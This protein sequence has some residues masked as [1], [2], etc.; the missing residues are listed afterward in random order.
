[1]H[2]T[3]FS[4]TIYAVR[5]K[6]S[7]S[8]SFN[9]YSNC[10]YERLDRNPSCLSSSSS[11][12]RC[13]GC[14][15]IS[16]Y[17]VPITPSLLCGL[18]QSSLLQWSSSRRLILSG[19]DRY[20]YRL[21]VYSPKMSCCELNCSVKE[22]SVCDRRRRIKEICFCTFSDEAS[23]ISHSDGYDEA[24]AVLSLLTEE[25]GGDFVGVKGKNVSSFKRLEVE[26][27]RIIGSREGNLSS[28]KKVEVGK[29]GDLNNQEKLT[30][31]LRKEDENHNEEKEAFMKGEKRRKRRNASSCS[32]YYSF[33]SSGD[34]ESDVEVQDKHG[35]NEEE[36]SV[37]YERE[38]SHLEGKMMEE[39]NSQREDSEK[40]VEISNQE[41]A[42]FGSDI[43]WNLRKKTEK[44]LTEVS[45]DKTE[46]MK[47]GQNML[48]RVSGMHGSNYEKASVSH[49]R[50]DSEQANSSSAMGLNK[51][52]EKE[53]IQDTERTSKFQ[54]LEQQQLQKREKIISQVEK[55]RKSQQISEL[56]Q[57]HES[58]VELE[59]T[60]SILKSRTS[61]KNWK[62]YSNLTSD[63]S[64]LY[65]QTDK[66]AQ[67]SSQPRKGS[68]LVYPISEAGASNKKQFSG[69][70][71][72]S[73]NVRFSQKSNMKSGV[74]TRD[75][76]C[77][78]DE[79]IT[80]FK[81]SSE[82]QRPTN[83]SI[84]TETGSI[85]AA[86]FHGSLNLISEAREQHIILAGGDI[87]SSQLLPIPSSSQLMARGSA[88]DE[89]TTGIADP[90]VYPETSES[91]SSS[92][93]N[94][95]S[96]RS[97]ALLSEPYS[98]DASDLVYSAPSH[99]TSPEDALGSADRL[100]KAS[101]QFVDDFVEKARHE[102]TTSE[103][104]DMKVT[105]A[106]L[107]SDQ[108][109]SLR[110]GTQNGSQLKEHESNHSSK[111]S[112]TK[113]PSDE[114]WHVTEPSVTQSSAAEESDDSKATRGP[115]VRRTGRSLW[116]IMG[117]IVRL[118]WG[119]HSNASTSAS[120]LGER[121]SSNKFDCE[122]W[123]PGQEDE[124]T[125][126]TNEGKERTS[127]QQQQQEQQQA[128]TSDQLE[129]G[130]LPTENEGEVVDTIKLKDK[131]KHLEVG[132]LSS[133]H[134]LESGLT[135]IGMSFA[136]KEENTS[137]TED[138]KNLKRTALGV[139]TM[140]LS[141]PLPLRVH[142]PVEEIVNTGSSDMLRTKSVVPTEEP[143][144]PMQA[145]SPPGTRRKDGELNQRKLQRNKQVL[146]DR[147][148]EWEEAHNLEQEQRK[149]D[150]VFMREALLEAKKA[151]DIWEVPVG[152]V[153]VQHGKIIARGCNLVEE[154]RDS[155]AHAEMI[156]IREA[157]N[158]LRSWRLTDTTLYVTLEPCPMCAGAILQARI[159]TLV[160]GAPNKLLGADGSWVRLF[161]DGGENSSE[162]GD[163]PPAPV[164]PFHPKMNI[165]RGVLATEC[166]D[167]MQQFFQLKRKK[168]REEPP[169]QPSCL[170]VTH[171]Q[172]KFFNKL[173]NV[174]NIVLRL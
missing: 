59:D 79:R 174:F 82:T 152:A 153:L 3:Y 161:P 12:C 94:N 85:E 98:V 133:S 103:I 68:E 22:R 28:G 117:D 129:T 42:R 37:G 143:S 2:N 124:E 13:C 80:Q 33:S 61:V 34:F 18:R 76:Y 136:S 49:K 16:N 46:S 107:A 146:R 172:S 112:G 77:Q 128:I 114:M 90:D 5:S 84:S 148:D 57:L 170:P 118:R 64:G 91:T 23:E 44:R 19:G 147:F 127:V 70:Q 65:V 74:K 113:G 30:V 104:Q 24:E 137:Q 145:E 20:F 78:T 101:K 58:D 106:N 131:A 31:D 102:V 111:L 115:I 4:S 158:L 63:V 8:L 138:G 110:H 35:Q 169:N 126:K 52:T 75:S 150:E 155:T 67:Q 119:S 72:T 165:R 151:A 156:C 26:K 159:E 105:G 45:M 55:Q 27:K 29:K 21:P 7:F 1:M 166:A 163:K 167:A 93:L 125:S 40:L 123:L 109:D 97:P 99:I 81:S 56:S 17:R 11:C 116:N 88:H 160:W 62:E 43:D 87:R 168:K 120:R 121:S 92:A 135:S 71:R 47:E 171:H 48:S 95:N 162:V 10:F 38:T 173:H 36:L 141:N 164:H 142:P 69:S 39:Y 108:M 51:K 66:R 157:S 60:S 83:F 89:P 130:K 154:L 86:S 139:G 134:M 14:C 96:G 54:G 15:E 149:I 32:S 122:T 100:E 140:E 50:F 41:R 144:A 25:A 132:V 73:G 6:G 9:D 53:N